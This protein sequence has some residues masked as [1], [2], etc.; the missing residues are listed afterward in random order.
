[1]Y[2]WQIA[3]DLAFFSSITHLTTL[4]CLRSYFKAR[5]TLRLLRLLY[6]GVVATMLACALWSTGYLD[7]S[8]ETSFPAWCLFHPGTMDEYRK[9]NDG[10]GFNIMYTLIVLLYLCFSYVARSVYLF[11]GITKA[12]TEWFR[13]LAHDA[14]SVTLRKRVRD[15]ALEDR[16]IGRPRRSRYCWI[17]LYRSILSFINMKQAM[18]DLYRSVFWEV[19]LSSSYMLRTRDC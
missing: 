15:K 1:M 3:V 16:T 9:N 4:T 14:I 6:M 12:L 11:S 7:G 13:S 18:T 2:H 19:Y 10:D 5:K 8:I 17:L